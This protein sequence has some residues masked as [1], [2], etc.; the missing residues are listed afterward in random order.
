M[1]KKKVE[2]IKNNFSTKIFSIIIHNNN[3]L[4]MTVISD[5]VGGIQIRVDCV[6]DTEKK[7]SKDMFKYFSCTAFI[8]IID[9]NIFE[10]IY[11]VIDKR[12]I[13]ML[14]DH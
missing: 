1:N 14:L 9:R 7:I 12:N 11:R 5:T 10:N 8:I 3:Y 2:L 13:E 4:I 6:F